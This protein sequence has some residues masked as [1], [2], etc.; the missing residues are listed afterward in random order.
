MDDILEMRL[1][2]NS[3]EEII[4]GLAPDFPY[5]SSRA[6]LNHYN[7]YWHWHRAVEL[8]FVESGALEYDTPQGRMVFPTGSGGLVNT[9][10]LHTSKPQEGSFHT[11]QLLHIF[12]AAF[13]FGQTESRVYQKYFSPIL[14]SPQIELIPLHPCEPAQKDVLEKL[15]DSF[16]LPRSGFGYEIRLREVLT[17]IWLDL[18]KL[19][20]PDSETSSRSS[21]KIKQMMAYV[22]EHFHED[23]SVVDIAAAGYASE[24]EC[25]R[26][27]REFL[28]T[29]PGE[30]IRNCRLQASC[31]MLSDGDSSITQISHAWD[32]AAAAFL[33]RFSFLALA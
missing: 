17:G 9:D 32:S 1:K 12:D 7:V 3:R 19:L 25:Y 28:H 4:G 22:H 27:F 31:R 20:P 11:V 14:A 23:I 8:F 15:K 2:G 33:E 24:R 6:F 18:L 26:A 16:E 10:V 21:R 30:Y 29:T 5:S 13:L